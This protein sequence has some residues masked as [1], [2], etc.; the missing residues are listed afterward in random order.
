MNPDRVDKLKA[1][2]KDEDLYDRMAKSLAPAI[3]GHHDVKKGVLMQLFSGTRKESP[4]QKGDPKMRH[5]RGDINIL[6]C[7]DP[8]TSKSQI[9]Q[10]VHKLVP[11]G[12][13]TSGKGSSAVGLT[14]YVTR[15]TDTK[16]LVLQTGALVMCDGG[17]CCIDEFDKMSDNTRSVLHEVMEQQTLSI[18]KAGIVCQLNARTSILAAANP[19]GSAWE[20]DKNILENVKLPDTLLSRFDLVYLLLDPNNDAYDKRLCRHLSSIY[21]NHSDFESENFISQD[22][23]KDY[24]AYARANIN[25]EIT[26]EARDDI[27]RS[28]LELRNNARLTSKGIIKAYPRN[29]ESLIRLS[30]AHAKMRLSS[31]VESVDVEEAFRLTKEALKI[32]STDPNTGKIGFVMTT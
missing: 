5:F 23:M 10:F 27:I 1:L 13:Y 26:P 11:R 7:G 14:A 9:L 30:E 16:Q 24:I 28:Y 12:Q 8:G 25:P 2:A 31:V 6:L 21:Q 19:T 15:D 4:G 3:F 20:A 32:S 29:L 17:I 18:A 22:V